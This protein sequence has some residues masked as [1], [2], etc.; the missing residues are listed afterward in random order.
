MASRSE[1]ARVLI[2]GGGGFTGRYVQSAL[3]AAGYRP[4]DAEGTGVRFD[5]R[6]RASIEAVLRATAPQY[7]IHLAAVSF[8]GHQDATEF[9]AVNSVGTTNLL[10]AVAS[11]G[12][13]LQRLIVASSANVYGNATVEP[14]R[15]DTAA[16]PA[17]HYAASKLAM[18][19]MVR[20]Y[21]NRLPI[22][23]TRPFNYTGVGQTAHF[24][25]PKLVEHF[26][27]RRA[28]VELGNLDVV[29][30]FS[31]VRAV[32]EAYVRLLAAE[33]PGGVTNLCSGIGQSL[34]WV[35]EQLSELSG[36][37][38]EVRVNQALVRAS[39][40][41]RLVGSATIMRAALGELPFCDFRETLKWMLDARTA[42]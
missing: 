29:R 22:L 27:Q 35:V 6:D 36:H 28:V 32:A 40:V 20:T 14:I 11:S 34:R 3:A 38:I 23:I 41:H 16:A 18:E 37:R 24:L 2:T 8:V 42:T 1:G 19:A 39:E 25:V 10:D 17:N 15:E 33:V 12:L 7:L 30:D 4:V 5:L 31:D 26:A 21:S 9:Y 13:G